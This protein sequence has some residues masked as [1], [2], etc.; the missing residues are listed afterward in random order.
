MVTNDRAISIT[1]FR[2]NAA[3]RNLREPCEFP[4]MTG[5]DHQASPAEREIAQVRAAQEDPRAFAPLYETYADLVWRYA[6]SRLGNH[7]LA[8]DATSL[9]FQR[10]LAALPKYEPRI[11]DEGSTFRPWLMTIARNVVLDHVRRVRPTHSLDDEANQPW[12]VDTARGPKS[13]AVAADER[14]RV[15]QALAQLPEVQQHIVRLRLAGMKGAEIADLLGKSE[16]A[17]KTA[18][19][20]AYARLKILLAEPASPEEA[21]R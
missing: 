14:R 10:V 3:V 8:A 1:Q 12:L 20:R 21:S 7:E 17:I 16:S 9:V 18:H 13:L 6:I 5:E 2:R 15:E 11:R 4:P 19:F